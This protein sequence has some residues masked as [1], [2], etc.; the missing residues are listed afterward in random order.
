MSAWSNNDNHN[1]KPKY[2]YERETMPV[3]Q[4]PVRTGNTSGN[5]IIQVSYND[6]GQNNVANVGIVANTYVYFWANGTADGKGG[7][8]GNGVPG[9]FA[10]N[11]TVASTSGNTITLNQNLFKTVSAGFIAEFDSS[12][13]Y[14]TNKTVEKTYNQDTVLVTAT[15]YANAI[16]TKLNPAHTGWTHIQRK[17]NN[18]GTVRY[19]TEVL[20]ATANATATNTASGNISNSIIAFTGV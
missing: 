2:N 19:I 4:L 20:V 17:I 9:F 8:S 14:S 6:G 18:D 15:R 7:T 16:S 12:I 13:V 1:S 5:N 10:S 11:T 3:I